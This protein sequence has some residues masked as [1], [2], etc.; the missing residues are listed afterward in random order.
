MSIVEWFLVIC[1]ADI[2]AGIVMRLIPKRN[3]KAPRKKR[4]AK[5]KTK[6]TNV[7]PLKKDL[8]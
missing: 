8:G 2:V 3:E 5:R 1:S 4:R 7:I 6:L